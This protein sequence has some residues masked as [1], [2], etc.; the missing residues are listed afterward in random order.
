MGQQLARGRKLVDKAYP[1]MLDPEY[2]LIL[3]MAGGKFYI[4][5]R[6]P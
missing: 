2:S 4:L 1:I 6:L 3:F 5:N